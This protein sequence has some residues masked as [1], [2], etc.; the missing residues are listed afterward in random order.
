VFLREL[1]ADDL[2]PVVQRLAAEPATAT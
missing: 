1:L 2:Q